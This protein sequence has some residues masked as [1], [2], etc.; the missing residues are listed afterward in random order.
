MDVRRYRGDLELK[1]AFY[2]SLLANKEIRVL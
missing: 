2:F 1:L